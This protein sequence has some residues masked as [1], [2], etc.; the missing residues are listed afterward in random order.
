[1][2]DPTDS[3]LLC[4]ARITNCTNIV[5]GKQLFTDSHTQKWF[6]DNKRNSACQGS[7]SGC[8]R[9][10]EKGIACFGLGLDELLEAQVREGE[11]L[12]RNGSKMPPLFEG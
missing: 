6:W 12:G 3:K 4:A 2:V 11:R 9:E 8:E 10:R 1:M 7:K 5:G